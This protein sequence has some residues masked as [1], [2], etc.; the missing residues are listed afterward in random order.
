MRKIISLFCLISILSS[1]STNNSSSDN[2]QISSA[3]LVKKVKVHHDNTDD[4][5]TFSYDGDKL[6]EVSDQNGYK[7]KNIYNGNLIVKQEVYINNILDFYTDYVYSSNKLIKKNTTSVTSNFTQNWDFVYN[8]DG[9]ITVNS[10]IP[11]SNVPRYTIYYFAN[12]NLIKRGNN[13]YTYDTKNNPFKNILGANYFIYLLPYGSAWDSDFGMLNNCL[14]SD[15]S[16]SVYQYN[17]QDY[18]ILKTQT[19]TS[20]SSYSTIIEYSY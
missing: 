20:N 10:P 14:L 18:P 17:V 4:F 7:M 16:I 15:A 13:N 1:C 12:G 8:S 2:S 6:L 9:T 19:S 3:V 11:G 5:F